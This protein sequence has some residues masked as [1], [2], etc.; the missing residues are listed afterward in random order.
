M[1]YKEFGQ[2]DK[3][4]IV[5][6]HGG[7]LSDWM[8]R[9]EI[10]AL[11]NEYTIITPII[12]G[13]GE[14]FEAAFTSIQG[15]AENIIAYIKDNLNGKVRAIC[16]LSLGAQITVEILSRASDIT[17]K[18]VIESAVVIP[19]KAA[20]KLAKSMLDI[21]FPL[22]QKLWFAKLQAK[23]L[24]IPG[25]MFESYF[26]DTKKMTKQSLLNMLLENAK[27]T[28]PEGFKNT[29]AKAAV[30]VGRKEYNVMKQSGEIIHKSAENSTFTEIDNCGHGVSILFP[31]KYLEILNGL[32]A[33]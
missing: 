25:N 33:E 8:W 20:Q 16:G 15:C 31:E 22:V 5:L 26:E 18:A 14:D 10:D 1:I 9:A 27:Y 13:H 24:N 28:L 12:D 21:S 17:E 29:A 30:I 3:P 32:L 6:I 2:K 4:V 19:S 7:G 11:K 23:Q